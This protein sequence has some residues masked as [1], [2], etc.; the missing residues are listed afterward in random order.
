LGGFPDRI[1]SHTE[2]TVIFPID[3]RST[4]I[5]EDIIT[6]SEYSQV[7]SKKLIINNSAVSHEEDYRPKP[8]IR[9]EVNK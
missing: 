5:C 8:N 4:C 1:Y 9:V 3:S 6:T 2:H 7:E